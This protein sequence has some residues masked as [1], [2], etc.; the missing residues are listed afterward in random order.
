MNRIK[1]LVLAVISFAFMFL[2]PLIAFAQEA[3]AAVQAAPAAPAMQ[4]QYQV[5]LALLGLVG[6]IVTAALPLV[7]K[8]VV[9]KYKL[10]GDLIHENQIEDLALKGIHFAEEQASKKLK[11][12]AGATKP[13]SSEKMNHATQFVLAQIEARKLPER[14]AEYIQNLIESKIAGVKGAGAA[15][16]GD[17]AK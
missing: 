12:A 1:I 17:A 11:A 7:I 14:S 6:T 15:N 5:L 10:E 2:F 13:N 4:W 9:R 3:V 16:I 8:Y